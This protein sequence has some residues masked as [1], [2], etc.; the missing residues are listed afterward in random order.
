MTIEAD[1]DTRRQEAADWFARLNQRK[2]TTED[3]KGFSAWRRDPENARAF[4]RL[5]TMWDAAGALGSTQDVVELTEAA[6]GRAQASRRSPRR[7][8]G[9]MT[10]TA[11]LG[12]V[13]LTLMA[14]AWVWQVR[15]PDTFATEIGERRVVRL[16]DGSQVTLD[17]ASRVAVRYTRE[18]RGITL[19][20]GQAQFEVR[21]DPTRPFTVRAG[22]TEVTA[23]GTTFDVRRFG[24]GARVVLVEGRVAV[25]DQAAPDRRWALSAGQQVVT[26]ASRPAVSAAD[27]LSA[28][29]WTTGRLMFDR[30]PIERAVAEVNRY[31][32]API[33]LRD[34]SIAA[35]EVSGVFNSGD[36]EGFV[37]ALLDLYPLRAER[38]ADGRT[39]LTRAS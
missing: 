37:A 8:Q 6:K 12:S 32:T 17:T 19:L 2:V 33:E 11:I 31:S 20:A 36:V 7:L 22:Q 25:S 28:T 27:V 15:Q 13:V 18:G 38:L 14:M 1:A 30:T 4:D 26:S 23:L 16:D 10:P 39:I 29:S 35:I 5:Q 24:D 21:R 34:P 9:L 3:V